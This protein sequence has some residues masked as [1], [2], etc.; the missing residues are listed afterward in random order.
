MSNN[1]GIMWVR[2]EIPN[3]ILG[4]DGLTVGPP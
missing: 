3:E 2:K 4:V 1:T